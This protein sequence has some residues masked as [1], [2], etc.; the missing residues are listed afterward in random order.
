MTPLFEKYR[1]ADWSEIVGQNNAVERL[2]AFRK[3]TGFGGRS[4]WITGASG[5]GKT[6]IARR[7]AIL[8]WARRRAGKAA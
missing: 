3:R 2:A 7:A 5:S 8:G 4:F 6:S 1:P